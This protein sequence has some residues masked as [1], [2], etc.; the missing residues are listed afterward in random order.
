M[1]SSLRGLFASLF[2]S[3][4]DGGEAASAAGGSMTRRDGVSM[5]GFGAMRLPTKEADGESVIDQDR[6]NRQVRQLLDG[7]CNFFDTSP[8]YCRGESE[9][10]LGEALVQSGYPRSGY[11]LSSKL[12]NFAESQWSAEASKQLFEDTLRYLHTD[13][14]D[15]YLLHSVAGRNFDDRFVKNGMMDWV[16]EQKR[17]G[18]I[19]K[20]GFSIHGD[21]DRFDWLMK[22]HDSGRHPW[23][24][25]L[26]QAN[27][28]DWRHAKDV[29]ARNTDADYYYRELDRRGIRMMV[30]EPLLGGRLANP[31]D[32]VRREFASL[33]P[34]ATA[35]KWAFR[36]F[37]SYRSILTVLSG[38]N[39]EEH[40]RENLATFSPL[41]PLSNAERIALERAAAAFAGCGNVPCNLCKYCMPCPYGLDIPALIAFINEVRAKKLGD[42][43]EIRALYER[44]VPDPRRRADRCIGCG[45][46]E[47]HCPQKIAVPKIMDSIAAFVEEYA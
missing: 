37:G 24:V 41:V 45:R 5:L 13:Y 11:F 19:R 25:V 39:Q 40:I 15:V 16:F 2:A 10:A 42:R 33:D 34:E 44:A 17:L 47:P 46:C 27:Y 32:D 26:I 21:P 35:A 3:V 38:M 9:K 23:D 6:V 14:L 36:F 12:S 4:G 28:V 30:M 8:R 29:N 22:E 20:V 18:R 1:E 43:R 7:G 31:P